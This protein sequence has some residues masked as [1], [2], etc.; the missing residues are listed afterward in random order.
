MM[1]HIH[2]PK[3][4]VQI[5]TISLLPDTKRSVAVFNGEVRSIDASWESELAQFGL[6]NQND[7]SIISPGECVSKS[8]I[9]NCFKVVLDDGRSFF[10][11]RYT[12][13]P[14]KQKRYWMRASKAQVE[15][16]GY[17]QLKKLAIPTLNVI[18]FGEKRSFGQLVAAYII[19]E[20]VSDSMDLQQFA[21]QV[22]FDLPKQQRSKTYLDLRSQIFEQLAKAHSIK[23]FHQDLHWRNI[24]VTEEEG[25]YKT[26]WIDCPRAAYRQ[27]SFSA[28]HGQMVDLSCLARRSLDYLSRS[29]RYRALSDYLSIN[30]LG[31]TN[32]ELFKEIQAHHIRSPN[33]PKSL[34]IPGGAKQFRP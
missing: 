15:V 21:A 4:N 1:Q 26:T 12:Y 34:N 11:K 25:R 27:L 7:W 23:F 19:T 14:S 20:G 5:K 8:E 16:F 31:W 24:L 18:A 9:T 30:N 2:G 32:R 3:A 17:A 6:T 28:K 10:F 29:E 22:W 13:P 33:P